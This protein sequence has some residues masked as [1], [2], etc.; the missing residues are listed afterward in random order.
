MSA[1]ARVFA[2]VCFRWVIATHVYPAHGPAT[3]IGIERRG[4]PFLR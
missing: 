2:A 3:T 4:N 1:S